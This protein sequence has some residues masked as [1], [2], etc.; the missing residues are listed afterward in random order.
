MDYTPELMAPMLADRLGQISEVVFIISGWK[1]ECE[2]LLELASR[3]RCHITVFVVGE[4]G[5]IDL[6]QHETA[7]T[8]NIHILSPD[9][10]LTEQV[11]SL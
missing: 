4:S 9:E 10:I 6:D 7:R 11:M 3:E 8:E 5:K 2:R 1:K